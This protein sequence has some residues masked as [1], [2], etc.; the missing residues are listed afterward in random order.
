M[1]V[2]TDFSFKDRSELGLYLINQAI[3]KGLNVCPVCLSRVFILVPGTRDVG[4]GERVGRGYSDFCIVQGLGP[5]SDF[6]FECNTG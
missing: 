6:I 1:F 2:Q 3:W 5:S 4:G